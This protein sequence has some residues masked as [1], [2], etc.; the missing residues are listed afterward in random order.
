MLHTLV[1]PRILH[2]LHFR[3]SFD[4]FWGG[5]V[6]FIVWHTWLPFQSF[7]IAQKLWEM[8]T[9]FVHKY[10]LLII[11]SA[12]CESQKEGFLN[13]SQSK[14]A[15]ANTGGNCSLYSTVWH[16]LDLITYNTMLLLIKNIQC[17][18]AG[19][20]IHIKLWVSGYD[21]PHGFLFNSD[22]AS[23]G[24]GWQLCRVVHNWL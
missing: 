24:C 3:C 23:V 1:D 17:R 22:C 6:G 18:T 2:F 20:L 7:Y 5:V 15:F 14:L 4:C 21:V 16:S 12:V 19:W 8:L 11:S 13:G 10:Y 9:W